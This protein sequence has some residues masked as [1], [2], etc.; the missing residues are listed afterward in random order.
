MCLFNPEKIQPEEDII[1]YKYLLYNEDDKGNITYVSPYYKDTVWK[2]G[3]TL[4]AEPVDGGLLTKRSIYCTMDM[5]TV[6]EGGVFHSFEKP[7]DAM[8]HGR[9]NFIDN[10]VVGKFVIPK[11]A[12]VVFSGVFTLYKS[13]YVN[14]NVYPCYGSTE[15][16][17]IGEV[18]GTRE[19]CEE[20][21]RNFF[22]QCGYV[23]NKS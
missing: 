5:V 10:T 16:K 1:V 3:E 12:K 6:V 13:D 7:E 14:G 8:H 9:F 15:L 22:E 18:P 23:P 17:F 21:H 4:T 19:T 11:D 2:E 20:K